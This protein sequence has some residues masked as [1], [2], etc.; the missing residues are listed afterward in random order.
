MK[1]AWLVSLTLLV[2]VAL[3]SGCSSGPSEDK[4]LSEVRAEAKKLDV[5]QLQ[6]KVDQYRKAIEAKEPEI[7]KLK[8]EIGSGIGQVLS[9][10]KPENVEELKE[11]L[12][13]LEASVKALTERMKIYADELKAKQAG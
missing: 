7:E 5:S 10:K 3:V 6:A 1:K 9:G 11:K 4:P 8:K 12:S 2:A 13:K